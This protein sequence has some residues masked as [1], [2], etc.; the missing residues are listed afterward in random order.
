MPA[1]LKALDK[2]LEYVLEDFNLIG[3]S[4]DATIRV[5]DGGVSRQHATI[6]RDGTLF[7]L[8][9]LGSANGS[10]V[11]DVAITTARALRHGDRIQFGTLNFMF[12]HDD[13]EGNGPATASSTQVFHTIALPV[14]KLKATLLVG[15][16]RNFTSISAKLS[17]DQ[18]ADLLREWYADCERI[19]KSRGAIIDKFIGDG[20]FA[21]WGATD[22]DTKRLATEAAMELSSP[23]ASDSPTRKKLK[24][25]KGLE[26]HCHVGLNIGEVALG[27]MGRGV[28]TAVGE[29]VNVTFRIESLTRKLKQPVLT[30]DAF[31]EGWSQSADY[32][33]P[34]GTHEV[35][36]QPEPVT[37]FS[38]KNA[39][40]IDPA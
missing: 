22:D 7:W 34:A 8:A 33:V 18:V 38:L 15:D 21:Y 40:Q 35:K 3:R 1:R 29:A 39:D 19:L 20:V 24:E 12:D 5:T 13:S 37:V 11:N 14:K 10:Y 30:S 9:D 36:G 4:N 16:L 23:E 31:L 2:D 26:V 25:E 32:Y 17:A 28:N 6:R 27:A